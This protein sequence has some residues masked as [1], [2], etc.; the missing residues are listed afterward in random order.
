[1]LRSYQANGGKLLFLNSKEVAK[2]VYP[3]YITGWI[4][5]TEGDIVVME[6]PEASVFNGIGVLDL[7]YF[8]NNKREIPLACTA[9]LKAVRHE[10]VE[11]L[12]SQ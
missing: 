4:I 11:E 1:M 6:R 2:K 9:T 12:A 5:P 10:N 8:N 7:R 3:E